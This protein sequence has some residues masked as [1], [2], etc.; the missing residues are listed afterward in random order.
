MV[1][2]WMQRRMARRG[3]FAASGFVALLALGGCISDQQ[4]V[5]MGIATQCDADGIVAALGDPAGRFVTR[6]NTEVCRGPRRD[7][8]SEASLDMIDCRS[9]TM[10]TAGVSRA[11]ADPAR[12]GAD[13]DH[14]AIVEAARLRLRVGL[15]DLAGTEAALRGAGVPVTLSSGQGAAQ[16]ARLGTSLAAGAAQT[17]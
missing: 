12:R 5:D 15:A 3:I 1:G 16:C 9:L 17:N 13:Y 7:S 2:Q 10:L 4:A 14:S 8:Y 6:A 11:S